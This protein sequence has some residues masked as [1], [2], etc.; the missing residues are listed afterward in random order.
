MTLPP[1]AIPASPNLPPW[2]LWLAHNML[3]PSPCTYTSHLSQVKSTALSTRLAALQLALEQE[4]KAVADGNRSLH[5]ALQRV[6]EFR[7]VRHRSCTAH[8][9]VHYRAPIA[10]HLI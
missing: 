5:A 8:P 3:L 9:T 10:T 2:Y 4:R 6:Q 7:C 1:P